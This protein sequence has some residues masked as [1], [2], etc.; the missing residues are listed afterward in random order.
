M[1][2][3]SFLKGKSFLLLSVCDS[4]SEDIGNEL[5][6]GLQVEGIGDGSFEEADH[7]IRQLVRAV[8]EDAVATVVQLE[9]LG[10]AA[11]VE[12]VVLDDR[13]GALSGTEEVAS[14][15][16]NG[17]GEVEVL[18]HAVFRVQRFV[19]EGKVKQTFLHDDLDSAIALGHESVVEASSVAKLIGEAIGLGADLVHLLLGPALNQEKGRAVH[20][21]LDVVVGSIVCDVFVHCRVGR[22]HVF[23]VGEA[24]RIGVVD[25]VRTGLIL[26]A[27]RRLEEHTLNAIW[28]M[29]RVEHALGA[30]S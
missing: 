25:P 12:P 4:V 5:S 23:F 11:L 19:E 6:P 15:V 14:A 26:D 3:K 1:C 13:V 22:N 17:D 9:D 10:A 27:G 28:E 20:I 2:R 7:V 21:F 8:N 24:D 30:T 16:L 18:E 29:T